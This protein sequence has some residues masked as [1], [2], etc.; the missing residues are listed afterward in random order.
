MTRRWLFGLLLIIFAALAIT[1]SVCLPLGEISDAGA[2]FR[3]IRFITETGRPPLTDAERFAVG[4]KGDASPVYHSLV[5]FLSQPVEVADLSTLPEV[6]EKGER[7][8]PD[9]ERFIRGLFH[10]EDEA[11][12][13]RGIVLAWHLAGLMSLPLGLATVIVL[14]LTLGEIFPDRPLLV[15]AATAWAAFIP[16]FIISS[17]VVNDDN[18]VFPLIAGSLYCL[19]RLIRGDHRGRIFIIL[20]LLMG[21]ATI[22]KYHAII[23]LPEMSLVIGWLAWRHRWGWRLAIKRWAWTMT[24]FSLAAG[25]WLIFV[26]WQFN[27]VEETGLASGVMAS[28]GDP[29]LTLGLS[30]LL[31]PEFNLISLAEFG[32]WFSWT[33]RSFW[34]HYNGI[35]TGLQAMGRE[36]IYWLPFWILGVASLG[37]VLGLVKAALSKVSRSRFSGIGT[38]KALT[39][40]SLIAGLFGL[41]L[42][43]YLGLSVTRYALFPAWSTAQGRHLYPALTSLAFFFI[44]GWDSL[45]AIIPPLTPARRD[46]ILLTVLGGGMLMFAGLTLP[47]WVMPVY[48]PY[49]PLVSQHPADLPIPH[50]LTTHF[51]NEGLRFE[52]YDMATT[53]SAGRALPV[54]LYWR[55]RAEQERDYVVQL[56][57]HDAN[58]QPVICQPTQPVNGR[59]PMRAWEVGYL[60][61]DEHHL[62]TPACLSPGAYDLQLTVWPLRNDTLAATIDDRLPPADPVALGSVMIQPSPQTKAGFAL[63]RGPDHFSSG[64]LTVWQLREA[65]TVMRYDQPAAGLHSE[66]AIWQPFDAGLTYHCPTG[67]SVTTQTFITH[68]GV[69]PDRYELR[70]G[71]SSPEMT[72]RVTTR[73]RDFQP[74]ANIATP[75]E[76]IFAEEVELLGY[77]VDLSP[78]QPGE[79][80]TIKTVWQAQR[81]MSQRHIGSI[82]LLDHQLTMW[83]Q[84]DHPLG[85]GYPNLLWAPGE[86]VTDFY[87]LSLPAYVPAG[88]YRL[89]LSVYDYQAGGFNP[90]WATVPIG[91]EPVKDLILGQ[92]RLTDPAGD[93]PPP[94]AMRVT[95][96]GQIQLLGYDVSARRLPVGQPLLVTL[97]WQAVAQ[98]TQDYTVFSQ[99]LGP[100]GQVWGQQDNQPQGGSYPTTAW[101]I[102]ERVVDR[103]E[104]RLQEGAPAG[105][106]QLLIGM[107]DLATG[108]RLPA[109]RENGEPWPN[110]AIMLIDIT[111]E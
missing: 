81:R 95:L 49:L 20:G 15:L 107:Y 85:G 42:L 87:E 61:R 58:Q 97:H 10:T 4:I 30:H 64:Q 40:N 72:V 109:M 43:I 79:T 74:P 71:A 18:L 106:Y 111:F 103:Y 33:F 56:C 104:L 77:E 53:L 86:V 29:V 100:D 63:W 57:L 23:L 34:L 91:D 11:F 52:G 83:S 9:D 99:L 62:P 90:L 38:A 50:R 80:I 21:L 65:L 28:L 27:D 102:E 16:R 2:H 44:L 96:A 12:P 78:R 13:W 60:I 93:E 94:H 41:H 48:Y 19:V 88:Q 47:V 59:Y 1:Y 36:T 24:T 45:L 98:P 26:T 69:K 6:H 7:S 92:I 82:H 32:Y 55:A 84:A 105:N 35:Y 39:T 73:R 37:A 70:L 67:E 89:K 25:W 68:A 110:A 76:A 8:I 101:P 5:A 17:A 108:N 31:S 75:V 46:K 54:T 14:Y 22:T 3:L 51:Y 66:T